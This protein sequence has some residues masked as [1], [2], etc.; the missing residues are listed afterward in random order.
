MYLRSLGGAQATDG[1]AA[2]AGQVDVLQVEGSETDDEADEMTDD[3]AQGQGKGHR[4]HP[5]LGRRHVAAPHEMLEEVSHRSTFMLA[6]ALGLQIVHA[7]Q[8]IVSSDP[9][10]VEP[11]ANVVVV[12][13]H[14]ESGVTPQQQQQSLILPSSV[15]KALRVGIVY[16]QARTLLR[17]MQD[18]QA[19][20]R[21]NHQ[22]DQSH[23]SMFVA[24]AG[25]GCVP[26]TNHDQGQGARGFASNAALAHIAA[27]LTTKIGDAP[28]ELQQQNQHASVGTHHQ[29]TPVPMKDC[30]MNMMAARILRACQSLR[31]T[32][33]PFLPPA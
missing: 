10:A 1:R 27:V 14:T 21:I 6:L 12:D 3:E 23:Q 4:S 19:I 25:V 26:P 9:A 31:L 18:I 30:L 24:D 20:A 22:T 33:R 8:I 29:S 16:T 5:P 15:R 17:T 13:H 2:Q 28:P 7:L 11:L 32:L